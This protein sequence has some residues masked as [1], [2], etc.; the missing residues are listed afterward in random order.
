MIFDTAEALLR[1]DRTVI[2]KAAGMADRQRL[3]QSVL[4]VA[5]ILLAA[6]CVGGR[7][8]SPFAEVS[9]PVLPP[10][11]TAEQVVAHLN[12]NI[13]RCTG[14]R[15]H[16]VSVR[17]NGHFLG[18]S[19]MMAVES[20][21]RFRMMVSAMKMDLA[22]LGSNDE[23]MWFWMRPAPD[24]PQYAYTCAHVDLAEAQRRSSLPFRPDWLMEVLGV[25]PIDPANVQMT[26]N[27]GD[28]CEFLLR[29]EQ[30]MDDG[31]SVVRIATVDAKTGV[32]VCHS[33][34]NG[35]TGQLI[36]QAKLSEHRRDERSG[37]SLP[38]TIELIYPGPAPGAADD[39]EMTLV[40]KEIEVNPTNVSPK[41]WQP[42]L[43]APC[44]DLATGRVI[45][46]DRVS[47]Q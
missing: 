34:W 22:D 20:P 43:A 36:A 23:R 11:A 4:L 19:A 10:D 40:L 32:I 31:T 25:M 41:T 15:C 3:A 26:V 24:Q 28:A 2:A 1:I 13:E 29:S 35:T 9:A 21:R 37:V 27:P 18:A 44:Q 8:W 6:G 12:S 39:A 46:L 14:W 17:S 38:H 33:L 47:R 16:N 7:G 42:N 5:S 45:T 30:Q